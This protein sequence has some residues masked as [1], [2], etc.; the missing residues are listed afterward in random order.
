M[1]AL[2]PLSLIDQVKAFHAFCL[3][4]G[5]CKRVALLFR[6]DPATIESLAHDFNWRAQITGLSRIDNEVGL[7][8]QQQIHRV[9]VFIVAERAK[10]IFTNLFDKLDSDPAFAERM[11]TKLSTDGALVVFDS[12]AL[13]DLVKGYEA[14]TGISYR[15]LG[16]TPE[17]TTNA[18]E[19]GTATAAAIGLATFQALRTRFDRKPG[20]DTVAEVSKAVKNVTSS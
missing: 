4:G 13:L 17:P 16:D 11:M 18:G 14:L 19:A 9:G 7:T 6:C 3:L 20:V 10:K 8:E 5:D 1:S 15:A 2:V 12:K